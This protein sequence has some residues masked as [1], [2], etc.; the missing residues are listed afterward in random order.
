MFN[1]HMERLPMTKLV[2]RAALT[3]LALLVTGVA[4]SQDTFYYPPKGRT[5]L[6]LKQDAFECY[7]WA[8][9]QSKFD[10]VEFAARTPS[11]AATTTNPAASPTTA[12]QPYD[13]ANPQVGRSVVGGAAAGAAVGEVAN[14]DAGQGALTGGALGLIRGKMAQKQAATERAASTAQA[15]AQAQLQAQLR[16]AAQAEDIKLKYESY[17]KARSTCYRGRGYTVSES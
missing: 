9:E 7:L 8:V 13:P 16:Q 6:Q 12:Q 17:Q 2:S 1:T 15:Q 4:N 14:N 5:D 11:A 10:P 3:A